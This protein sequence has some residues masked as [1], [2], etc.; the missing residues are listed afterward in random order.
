MMIKT[1]NKK[2]RPDL[3]ASKINLYE[4][5]WGHTVGVQHHVKCG[6]LVAWTFTIPRYPEW[7]F[8]KQFPT[9]PTIRRWPL[10]HTW[11]AGRAKESLQQP[12]ELRRLRAESW[13]GWPQAGDEWRESSGLA[14]AAGAAGPADTRALKELNRAGGRAPVRSEHVQFAPHPYYGWVRPPPLGAGFRGAAAAAATRAPRRPGGRGH[15]MRE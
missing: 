15:W 5:R 6:S 1:K 14:W 9:T 12:P 11:M 13:Q 2:T 4:I 7:M 3:P 10:L 8:C